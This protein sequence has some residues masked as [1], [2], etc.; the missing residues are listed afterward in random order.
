VREQSVARRREFV[1]WYRAQVLPAQS[2]RHTDAAARDAE[3]G[4]ARSKLPKLNEL[5]R[6]VKRAVEA[7]TNV[8]AL[9]G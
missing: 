2:R 3:A 6:D 7:L 9:V 8:E 4:D 5:H 1:D